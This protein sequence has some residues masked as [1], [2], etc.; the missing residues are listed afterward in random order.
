MRYF[1]KISRPLNVCLLFV[2]VLAPVAACVESSGPLGGPHVIEVGSVSSVKLTVAQPILALGQTTQ[3]TVVARSADGQVVSG[4]AVF[5]SKNPSIATVSSEGVVSAL[6]AGVAMI[7]A[8]VASQIASVPVTV[9]AQAPPGSPV[10]VVAVLLDSTSLTISHSAIARAT[11]MDSAGNIISGQTVT[12]VSLSPTVA[13]VVST[14]TVTAVAA[15][16][17]TIQA[18]ASGKAG[19][20][21]LTVVQVPASI[22][23]V[24]VF[25][26]F[27]DGTSGSFTVGGTNGGSVDFPDDP[28]GSGRGKVARIHYSPT[29]T[30]RSDD[31]HVS[32]RAGD[33]GKIRYGR[34]I[35]FKGDVY[36][37]TNPLGDPNWNAND[38]RKVLDWQGQSD[39]GWTTGG[40]RLYLGRGPD[41]TVVGGPMALAIEVDAQ[42]TIGGVPQGRTVQYFSYFADNLVPSD[43]WHTIE[44]R[45]ITNS[46]DGAHDGSLAFWIDNPGPTPTFQTAATLSFINEAWAPLNHVGVPVV[47]SYFNDFQQGAQLSNLSPEPLNTEFRYWDNMGFSKTRILR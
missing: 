44:V 29:L 28:T 47:G 6:T 18:T 17:A 34:T 32:W 40:A 25:H 2:G 1:N 35:W 36:F 41:G 20:A 38:G 30:N 24:L 27:N 5:S 19:S 45:M 21:L 9:K 46:A 15:G 13:T 11:V 23:S 10:A 37:P 42:I 12:W 26:D 8:V 39:D 4:R 16:S 43:S 3:A 14:G 22:D 31:E 33:A 7:Q